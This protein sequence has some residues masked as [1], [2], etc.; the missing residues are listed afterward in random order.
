MSFDLVHAR[1]VLIH[2]VEPEKVI[3]EMLR[4]LKPGGALML[5]EPD[6]SAAKAFIGPVHLKRAFDSVKQAIQSTF[7]SRSMNYAFGA[8]LPALLEERPTKIA[9]IDYDCPVTPGGDHLAE[10]MR[11]STLALREKYLATGSVTQSDI[12]GY[13]E[14]ALTPQCWGTYYATVRVLAHKVVP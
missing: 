14:F 11:L 8:A 10:M 7:E 9:S 6:F 13:A 5:E 12:D 1:Y 4:C 3:D 2:N